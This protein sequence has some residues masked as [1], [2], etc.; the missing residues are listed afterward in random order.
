M[1]KI[2][3]NFIVIFGWKFHPTYL[4]VH[5]KLTVGS[6][7]HTSSAC[8]GS[9]FVSFGIRR[10]HCTPLTVVG[11]F[12]VTPRGNS[13]RRGRCSARHRPI[14]AG[15]YHVHLWCVAVHG[16]NAC[17]HDATVAPNGCAYRAGLAIVPWHAPTRRWGPQL[18]DFFARM[19]STKLQSH[20]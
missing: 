13:R 11:T 1:S 14:I 7:H 12:T 17:I 10:P 19:T 5:V 18:T 3:W 2:S 9:E 16:S 8:R 4:L 20:R 6:L 15:R